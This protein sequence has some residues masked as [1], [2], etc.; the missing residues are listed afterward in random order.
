MLRS[1]KRKVDRCEKM[2]EY[3]VK[4]TK[5]EDDHDFVEQSVD[6]KYVINGKDVM[7]I[8]A[9]GP[10]NFGFKL[11]DMLFSKELQKSLLYKSKRSDKE[12]LDIE[13]VERLVYLVNQRYSNHD[14]WD[15]QTLIK[16]LHQKCRDSSPRNLK[17]ETMSN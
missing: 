5:K 3:L 4:R 13:K 7:R 1:L 16:K 15:E 14:D 11:L 8:H 10:Y 9:T 12:A 17:H 2:L 6:S